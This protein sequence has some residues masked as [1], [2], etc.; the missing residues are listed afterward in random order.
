MAD[1][2]PAKRES[3]QMA[4]HTT[5][6]TWIRRVAQSPDVAFRNPSG[7][8][9]GR[10][11]I[12]PLLGRGGMGR[13]Y[14]AQDL[15][16]RRCVA[17]KFLRW[18]P[19]SD[20]L[21]AERFL[22]ERRV[23]AE[24]EHP[25]IVPVY[26]SG[27]WDD[28]LYY[29]MRKVSG[30]SLNRRMQR[31]ETL[32][33]RLGLLGTLIAVGDAVAFAHSHGVIHRDLKPG[34]I[35]VGPFGETLVADWGLAKQL[36]G[37]ETPGLNGSAPPEATAATQAGRVL[38]TPGYMAPEQA[39]GENVDE[40]A[41]VYSLGAMLCELFARSLPLPQALVSPENAIDDSM[42]D[43][44][45][46]IR[47]AI[48][49]R[50]E[51]RY[52]NA[53]ELA[54]ELRRFQTGQLVH[55][56]RYTRTELLR[57]WARRYRRELRIAV[58]L[59]VVAGALIAASFVRLL[60]ERNAALLQRRAAESAQHET[61][62]RNDELILQRARAELARDPTASL[63]LLKRYPANGAG[64][65][66]VATI[67]AD[68]WAR[69]VAHDVWD[70]G[71]PV[72]SVAFSPDGQTIGAGAP[73]GTLALIDV[74]TG[75][76]RTYR[77]PESIGGRIAF[78]HDGSF[79]ATTDIREHV[80]LWDLRSG[81]SRLLPKQHSPGR[82]LGGAFAQ[83]APDD[84]LL[85][86]RLG[87]ELPRLWRIP[88]LEPVPMLGSGGL[89]AFGPAGTLLLAHDRRLEIVDA[90]SWQLRASV[91][92]GGSP[93]DLWLSGD[94]EWVAASFH[95][96]L[97]AWNPSS[98]VVQR[99]SAAPGV[100]D[101]IVPAPAGHLF[102]SCGLSGEA[103]PDV[104]VFDPSVPTSR[105]LAPGERCMRTNLSFSSD[106]ARFVSAGFGTELRVYD[107]AE[108][109]ARA[110]LGHEAA[111]VGADFS[112]D[113]RWVASASTDGTVRLWQLDDGVVRNVHGAVALDRLD[114]NGE[115]LLA[116]ANDGSVSLLDVTSGLRRA[117]SGPRVPSQSR[118]A[119]PARGRCCCCDQMV[120]GALS[121]DGRIAAFPDA[122]GRLVVW[123]ARA[124]APGTRTLGAYAPDG[125]MVRAE[126]LSTDG[127]VLAQVDD[128]GGV[129]VL[130]TRSGAE[131][132]IARLNDAGF[133]VALSGDGRVVAA[134]GRAG[135]IGAWDVAT[136]K[137][138][139]ELRAASFMIWEVGF[140]RD[141]KRLA[142][143][144]TDGVIY[145]LDLPTGKVTRLRGQR[146]AVVATDF[147]PDGTGIFSGGGDGTVR[148][149]DL[150]SGESRTLIRETDGIAMLGFSPDGQRL[151][152]SGSDKVSI[153]DVASL[154]MF[155]AEPGS[156][157][158]EWLARQTRVED[159]SHGHVKSVAF[160]APSASQH[161]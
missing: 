2:E 17:I 23:T 22:R 140:S 24:L 68:A 51:D 28:Q 119:I 82:F 59:A 107:I 13:V 63:A 43:L 5:I 64:R 113:G 98:G 121:R 150:R 20:T 90:Q 124:E 133:S 83:F 50:R 67:A 157:L 58:A 71:T 35:L 136:G 26:D 75:S 125:R 88:S 69:G 54:E 15:E 116:D 144:A 42:G 137:L 115:I 11:R 36:N 78:S 74:A 6:D 155:G 29:V 112:P 156:G 55:A 153:W 106:G 154:P 72:A 31:A 56:H 139:G 127:A 101:T 21:A 91:G 123:D 25:G 44:A 152:V 81:E 4:A 151:L 95:D 141:G 46:I 117:L 93:N 138:Q 96:F 40:R 65:R 48:S 160:G 142:A 80:R 66:E 89:V 1:G 103:P 118:G 149:R 131:H 85:L 57:R 47:K 61:A 77:S 99:F 148:W 158:A 92:I 146:G 8:T 10:Y 70:L 18:Q 147:T 79:A 34:N 73:D 132:A 94:G 122:N 143:A 105:P 52:R 7:E 84:S 41:D 87:G 100:V 39:R 104:W 111:I 130:D 135:S 53:A 110:L 114:D 109:R 45:A 159:D 3:E 97:M 16:L 9:I 108:G 126:A 49:P 102:A 128:A 19:Q 60:H 30:E 76:L 14:E 129:R 12:G 86:V 134:A 27:I 37:H 161:R 32:E 120:R 38:G 145:L 33:Q 62:I